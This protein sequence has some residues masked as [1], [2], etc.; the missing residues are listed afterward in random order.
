M[1]PLIH[2][3]RCYWLFTSL[4]GRCA[5]LK[6]LILLLI[7]FV[8]PNLHMLIIMPTAFPLSPSA[9][10]FPLS[11]DQLR[12]LKAFFLGYSLVLTFLWFFP[13]FFILCS[14]PC[15]HCSTSC[16]HN[17]PVLY[18]YIDVIEGSRFAT[19][20]MHSHIV[21]LVYIAEHGSLIVYFRSIRC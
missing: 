16:G 11:S 1:L 14:H 18:M 19:H 17:T 8:V 21:T 9:S 2:S 6:W 13:S 7:S 10:V 20:H 5:V 3:R 15:R 12:S 4:I